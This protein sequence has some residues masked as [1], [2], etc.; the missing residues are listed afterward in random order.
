LAAR[1]RYIAKFKPADNDAQVDDRVVGEEASARADLEGQL[2]T[3]IGPSNPKGFAGPGK[4]NLASLVAGDLDFGQLDGVVYASQDDKAHV[5]V[6]T[7]VL[8]ENWLRVHKDWWPGLKNVPQQVNA[9]LTSD[10]FYTQAL[11][12]EAAV[13]QYAVLPIAKPAQAT[14]AFAMLG[15][16]S[17]DLGPWTPEELFVAVVAGGRVFVVSAGA[18]AEIK[19]MPACL[20]VWQASER[21]AGE[22]MSAFKASESKNETLFDD[23]L[24]TQEDG[25]AAFRRCYAERVT[26]DKAFP[27][28][29]KQ[30]QALA[31]AVASK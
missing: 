24:R 25:D 14:F 22:L 3:I 19:P 26:S 29:I 10:A 12:T 16:R 13:S 20:E 11:S 1:D 4:S 7:N 27:A 28:L 31:D 8:F 21:K 30:A 15:A 5:I 2:R 17:Q 23:Y 9:A 18:N 6:T